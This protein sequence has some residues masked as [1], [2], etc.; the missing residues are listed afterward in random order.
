VTTRP[1]LPI[2]SPEQNGSQQDMRRCVLQVVLC[3]LAAEL[4]AMKQLGKKGVFTLFT[5]SQSNLL[6]FKV[7]LF[8]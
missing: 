7:Y 2:L 4:M 5:L 8:I 6:F 3:V 1:I